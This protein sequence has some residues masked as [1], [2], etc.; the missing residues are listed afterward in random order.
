MGEV[1]DIM[2]K[3]RAESCRGYGWNGSEVIK[4]GVGGR[5]QLF[6]YRAER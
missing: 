5:R 4:G 3:L 1:D 6:I 2:D